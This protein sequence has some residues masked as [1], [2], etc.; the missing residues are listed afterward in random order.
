[1]LRPSLEMFEDQEFK[2][3]LTYVASSRSAWALWHKEGKREGEK[4]PLQ[5]HEAFFLNSG[6]AMLVNQYLIKL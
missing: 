2:V 3:I 4:R 6:L 1:M 5:S